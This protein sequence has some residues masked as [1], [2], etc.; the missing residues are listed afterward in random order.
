MRCRKKR[1]HIGIY[2]TLLI[3]KD[4]H[5]YITAFKVFLLFS[6]LFLLISTVWMVIA[7][8]Y[9]YNTTQNIDFTFENNT[10][11]YDVNS[12]TTT[13]LWNTRQQRFLGNY[14]ATY[15]FDNVEFGTLPD[16]EY[17]TF[18]DQSDEP[19]GYSYVI[20]EFQNHATVWKTHGDANGDNGYG[21][22]AF[23][24]NITGDIEFWIASSDT[25]HNNMVGI[26]AHAPGNP[27]TNTA[28][29][30]F[31]ND[32]FY[33]YD[34]SHNNLFVVSDFQWYHVLLHNF[35]F[36]TETY[37]ITVDGTNYGS[38]DFN[39]LWAVDYNIGVNVFCQ[40]NYHYDMYLDALGFDGIFGYSTG[41][42]VIPNEYILTDTKIYQDI[43]LTEGSYLDGEY[44][45][46]WN[47]DGDAYQ[48]DAIFDPGTLAY[49]TTT[50]TL[51]FSYPLTN[52]NITISYNI[53]SDQT[54]TDID[55]FIPGTTT[56]SSTDG[57]LYGSNVSAYCSNDAIYISALDYSNDYTLFIDYIYITYP[58][59]TD[60]FEFTFNSSGNLYTENSQLENDDWIISE[61]NGNLDIESQ[62]FDK[63]LN[64]FTDETNSNVSLKR[65]ITDTSDDYLQIDYSFEQIGKLTTGAERIMIDLFDSDYNSLSKIYCIAT[66]GYNNIYIKNDSDYI[67]AFSI[68]SS[69]SLYIE[70]FIYN[71]ELT[72]IYNN[73]DT[74]TYSISTDVQYIQFSKYVPLGFGVS[75]HDTYLD[76]V[77][78][79]VNGI[80]QS[81]EQP[82]AG[83]VDLEIET[84]DLRSYYSY[85]LQ[86]NTDY[87]NDF[88]LYLQN[89]VLLY[90]DTLLLETSLNNYNTT[91]YQNGYL[92]INSESDYRFTFQI[93][94]INVRDSID[95]QLH[96][97]T[98]TFDDDTYLS[99][100]TVSSEKLY[101]TFNANQT[102]A[103][104]S[105]DIPNVNALYR[106]MSVGGLKSSDTYAYQLARYSDNSY[107]E[108]Q[109]ELSYS[110]SPIVLHTD[111]TIDKIEFF[112][113]GSFDC[114]GYYNSFSLDYIPS[115]DTSITI[116]NL[117]TVI[118]PLLILII[119]ST[120]ISLKFG[121]L[122]FIVMFLLMTIITYIGNMIPTWLF[123][124]ILLGCGF[125]LFVEF[126]KNG[127][128]FD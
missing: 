16:N 98:L 55:L 42:N 64:F 56:I 67:D 120:V 35:N 101:F 8:G 1:T 28:V 111:K 125:F 87:T 82:N 7:F 85:T 31:Y 23:P 45:D 128:I 5:L 108:K 47:L 126:T 32:N 51:D 41:D 57:I 69:F 36:T 60:K 3:D 102:Y 86:P 77:G 72:I 10:L 12:E 53:T 4:T 48:I 11:E 70:Y 33:W 112:V 109:L 99:Y 20:S 89:D 105:F 117:L 90:N 59:E 18:I 68:A 39:N 2:N 66:S 76:Y 83:F 75:N 34:G 62:G 50:S 84:F 121:K 13:N 124:I 114:T 14:T 93:H 91:V 97:G 40:E 25:T 26:R 22:S 17:G 6:I 21:S 127:D 49:E 96:I 104:M 107:N 103:K 29:V 74:Y 43:V 95:N 61:Q 19:N 122:G 119:P 80:S 88:E 27:Y 79:Y 46:T 9:N 100:F 24:F 65:E 73:T 37:N 113:N 118:I 78:I 71:N 94:T 81:I 15:S 110:S 58:Y 63:V 44:N 54:T 106:K 38:A 123:F 52:R 115:L 116:S 30:G 92:F